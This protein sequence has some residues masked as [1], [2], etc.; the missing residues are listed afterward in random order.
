MCF[1]GHGI[2]GIL[3]K[4]V[5]CDY[6]AL[7]GIGRPL[8]YQLMPVVGCA[9]ILMGLGVLFYPLRIFF[10]WLVIWG[11]STAL[12]RPLAGEPIAEMF[13]RAGNYGAP[14][15]LLILGAGRHGN[16]I[17]RTLAPPLSKATT[18]RTIWC[19]K[20]T[21]FC[22]LAGHGWLNLLGKQAWVEQ[23]QALSGISGEQVAAILGSIELAG[24]L[25]VLTG[26]PANLLL[27]FLFWK[28]ITE[29]LYT[30]YALIEW[31]E[32]GAS[33]GALLALWL[34]C[35]HLPSRKTP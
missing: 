31:V 1:I 6:F 25:L 30:K 19:L 32:R 34:L 35:S 22:L 29:T 13:E 2:F 27:F 20:V 8:A 23:Y 4:P 11:F 3:T 18:R 21:V 9:D 7:F 17:F 33:Y 10:I 15:A 28:V 16:G 5:W 26:M 12:F 24:A 14:L